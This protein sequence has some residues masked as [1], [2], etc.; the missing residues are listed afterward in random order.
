[1][2]GA[3]GAGAQLGDVEDGTGPVYAAGAVVWRIEDG[4]PRILLC[5]RDRHGDW[6]LPKGKVD[7]GETLPETAAREVHEETGFRVA[8][9]APLGSI[10]YVL[11]NGRPKEV[12]YWMAELGAS[13]AERAFAPNE[14]VDAI[15]WTSTKRARRM[16]SYERDREVMDLVDERFARGTARTFP[17]IALRH[18]KA[19]PPLSW[20]GDDASRPLTSRGQEQA[21]AVVGILAAY[22]PEHAITS[23]AVRCRETIAPFAA[24]IGAAAEVEGSISQS[25]YDEDASLE[26]LV[27]RLLRERRGA[28]LCSHS[29]VVPELVAAVADA[30][31]T[32]LS[33]LSRQ[34][35]LST[36]ECAVL[37]IP[38][39][40]PRRGVV[41]AETHGPIA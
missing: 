11:P 13:E 39:D 3:A 8:L 20:P 2:S 24:S 32:R 25:A 30:T 14:E 38:A 10:E 4:K 23:P 26:E 7:D 41:A 18:G 29:P 36:G 12:H 6:S 31:G 17:I 21:T 37:H 40:H 16:L 15:E 22:G 27:A 5:H 33:L 34:S 28:V 1:M 9:G 35:M 19:T